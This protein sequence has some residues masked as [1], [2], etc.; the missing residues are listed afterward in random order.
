MNEN[1]NYSWCATIS[2]LL[3]FVAGIYKLKKS[4]LSYT[5]LIPFRVSRVT[6]EHCPSPEFAP[7]RTF[8]DYSGGKSLAICG[9]F[10]RLGIWTSYGIPS[11]TDED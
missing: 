3:L 1:L 10:D 5:R 11:Y 6:S 7:G 4:N 2:A 8:Q 9:R